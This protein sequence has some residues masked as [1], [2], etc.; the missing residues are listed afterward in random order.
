MNFDIAKL[1]LVGKKR[2]KLTQKYKR[3]MWYFSWISSP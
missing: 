2:I 3:K 1:R